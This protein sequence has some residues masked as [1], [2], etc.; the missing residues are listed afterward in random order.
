MSPSAALTSIQSP[1][2]KGAEDLFK[3]ALE[4]DSQGT[5]FDQRVAIIHFHNA[6][7]LL[8]KDL[9]RMNGLNYRQKQIP[10]LVRALKGTITE[11][12]SVEGDLMLLHESRN[13][14]YHSCFAPDEFN[15]NWLIS[16]AQEFFGL[17]E[18]LLGESS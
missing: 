11:L 8:L 4:H 6:I 1:L 10:Q 5:I 18:R 17:I 3:H 12:G 14:V 9:A 13:M 7:E 15:Y 16:K 2:R